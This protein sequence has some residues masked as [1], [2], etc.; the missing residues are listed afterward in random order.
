MYPEDKLIGVGNFIVSVGNFILREQQLYPSNKVLQS[1]HK[2]K[3]E[4]D[5]HIAK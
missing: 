4:I 1:L 2:I 5:S 3:H